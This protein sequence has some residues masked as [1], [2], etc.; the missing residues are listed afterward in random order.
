[1]KVS[2]R[3]SLCFLKSAIFSNKYLRRNFYSYFKE[4][5]H[6]ERN[7]LNGNIATLKALLLTVFIFPVTF[8]FFE[9]M[10]F[11][12]LVSFWK[13]NI[14][15]FKVWKT[16]PFSYLQYF[17]VLTF[18]IFFWSYGH[19][20]QNFVVQLSVFLNEFFLPSSSLWF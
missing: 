13:I 7:C 16:T 4:R 6:L 19:K 17:T 5:K 20:L 14:S 18:W 12:S 1:M 10:F 9:K 2:H 15:T 11:F 3:L 8:N